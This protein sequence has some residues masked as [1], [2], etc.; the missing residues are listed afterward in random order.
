MDELKLPDEMRDVLRASWHRYLDQVLPLRPQLHAYCRRLTRDLWD[1]EDLAQESLLKAFGMLGR[2]DNPIRNPR[3]Y[4]LRIATNVWIDTLRR[5]GHERDI[6]EHDQPAEP[7]PPDTAAAVR[8]AGA[9]LLHRLPPRERAALMLKDVFD[10]S[11]EETADVL[12]TTV[13]AIKSALHR[14]RTRLRDDD[15]EGSTQRSVPSR[16]LVDQF[17]ERLQAR[18][19]AGLL[20]LVLENAPAEN[21][22]SSYQFGSDMHQSDKSWFEGATSEH[23]DWPEWLRWEATKVET[24]IYEGEPIILVFHVRGGVDYLEIVLRLQEEDERVASL[25]SYGFC[26]EVMREIGEALGHRVN[27]G[28]YRYPTPAPGASYTD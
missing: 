5:R 2:I 6:H 28:L 15:D 9:V 1:A 12:E 19:K 10:M 22:G 8:S 3:A 21:V 20:A 7:S 17:A 4:L 25:R 18:D 27:T 24:A 26:P 14:G 13:G 16:A 23:P 11:L